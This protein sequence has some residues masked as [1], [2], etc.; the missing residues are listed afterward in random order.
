MPGATTSTRAAAVNEHIKVYNSDALNDLLADVDE[1][2][3]MGGTHHGDAATGGLGSMAPSHL[4]RSAI[5]AQASSTSRGGKGATTAAEDEEADREKWRRDM[6]EKQFRSRMDK[7]HRDVERRIKQ[8]AEKRDLKFQSM[9][10]TFLHENDHF[11]KD[12]FKMVD[13]QSAQ[14]QRKKQLMYHEWCEEVFDKIQENILGQVDQMDEKQ[15]EAKK[16]ALY[17]EFLDAT[18]RKDGL[19]RDIIIESDYDPLAWREESMR[20]SSKVDDPVKREL[21]R[22]YNDLE[23]I[24]G[25][26]KGIP[27]SRTKAIL[28]VKMWDKLEATPHGKA[29]QMFAQQQAQA[30][31]PR[32]VSK[33]QAT[34]MRLNHYKI[35]M[36]PKTATHELHGFYGTRGRKCFPDA[37][38]S[39][40]LD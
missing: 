7:L 20:Y 4:S 15:I 26:G 16:N 30:G 19:F 37:A 6:R 2:V 39:F 29:A 31:K 35:D 23:G 32:P 18:R 12:L 24:G 40:A 28:D 14:D 17:Q 36:K 13:Y 1:P 34:T 25:T 21:T 3:M 33:T 11:V 5:S 38:S 27:H 8:N 9:L 22:Q 10:G